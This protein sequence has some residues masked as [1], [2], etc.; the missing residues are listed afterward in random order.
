MA[1]ISATLAVLQRH[2]LNGH[3]SASPKVSFGCGNGS[4]SAVKRN[5][6]RSRVD[7]LLPEQLPFLQLFAPIIFV[8][9]AIHILG[10]N[11][12]ISRG[13]ARVYVF[14]AV[15]LIVARYVSWRLSSTVLPCL[16]YTSPSPRD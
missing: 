10:P 3:F 14:A 9:G 4:V 15:W 6:D 8:F 12:P 7:N 16:L 5:Q 1:T 13:W 2:V 11:L